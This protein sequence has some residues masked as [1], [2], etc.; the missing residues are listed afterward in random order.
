[1]RSLA[2]LFITLIAIFSKQIVAI[3]APMTTP[4]LT[5]PQLQSLR[6]GEHVITVWRDPGRD[7]AA[8]DVFGAIDIEATV[9]TIWN[10]MLDCERARIIVQ[11][12]KSCKI[13]ETAPDGSW[14]VREQITKTGFLLPK[15]TSVFR[16]DYDLYKSIKISLAGGDMKVQDGLWILTPLDRINTRVTYRAT[17]LSKFAVPQGFIK[18]AMR[19]DVPEVLGNMREQAQN[20]EA[21]K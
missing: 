13:L 7:D 14:D 3:A 20:D 9:E 18:S 5:E 10:M 15:N 11:N 16:S 4:E 19:K 8:L 2:T 12:M 21:R 1:M 17:I 6:N